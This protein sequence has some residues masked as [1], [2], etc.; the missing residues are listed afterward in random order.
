M[1][2]ARHGQVHYGAFLIFHWKEEATEKG[3]VVEAVRYLYWKEIGLAV[4]PELKHFPDRSSDA[5]YV[6][7]NRY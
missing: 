4:K 3:W 7:Q 2:G 6:G 1:N 5:E